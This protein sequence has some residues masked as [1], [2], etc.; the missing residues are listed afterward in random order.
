MTRNEVVA[1]A[2]RAGFTL[3][4]TAAG[5]IPLEEWQPYGM[6]ADDP[7]MWRRVPS[8]DFLND[9]P[10]GPRIVDNVPLGEIGGVWPLG[11]RPLVTHPWSGQSDTSDSG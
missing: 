9:L 5:V 7:R 10:H 8:W 4:K 11:P 6:A 3:I 2:K 1:A